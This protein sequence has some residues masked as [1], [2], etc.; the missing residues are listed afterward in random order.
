MLAAVGYLGAN[1]EIKGAGSGHRKHQRHR[2]EC[3][4]HR[5]RYKCIYA[6]KT[7]GAR[8]TRNQTRRIG[9]EAGCAPHEAEARAAW[10]AEF[11]AAAV[12]E[13]GMSTDH[14]GR[15]RSKVTRDPRAP[16]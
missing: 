7:R 15:R 11:A 1:F 3:L 9:M 13:T 16:T 12:A 4:F 8:A 6:I 5:H 2:D 14:L 10:P